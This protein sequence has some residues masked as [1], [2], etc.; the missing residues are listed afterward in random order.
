MKGASIV[1]STAFDGLC[2]EANA[3]FKTG[4]RNRILLPSDDGLFTTIVWHGDDS[5]QAE[6]PHYALHFAGDDRLTFMDGTS[7]VG[8]FVDCRNGSTTLH[9]HIRLTWNGDPDRRLCVPAGI[10]HCPET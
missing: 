10:A 2:W 3:R 5:A 9:K 7:I 1:E 4:P 6:Y 8:E